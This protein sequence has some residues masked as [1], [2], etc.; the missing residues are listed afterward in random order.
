[1]AKRAPKPQNSR[2]DSAVQAALITRKGPI[3]AAVITVAGVILVGVLGK[4]GN[5]KPG[6][7]PIAVNEKFVGRIIDKSTEK[8]IG[9]AKI[10]LESGGVPAVAFSDSEGIFS[11][12]LSDANQETHIRVEASGYQNYDLRVVPRRNEEIQDIRLTPTQLVSSSALEAAQSKSSSSHRNA[13]PKSELGE[14]IQDVTSRVH[15]RVEDAETGKP[16]A[17]ARVTVEGFAKES[18]ITGLDGEF[19]LDTHKTRNQTF[20]LRA[21]KSGYSSRA[22]W[23]EAGGQ[24]ATIRLTRE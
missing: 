6:S 24:R 18:T 13:Q 17:G 11:F 10:S 14:G 4:C 23:H 19:D 9:Q 22:Q 5:D 7:A 21:E 2:A 3:V 8:R 20:R 1:M 15:G 16:I 12:P